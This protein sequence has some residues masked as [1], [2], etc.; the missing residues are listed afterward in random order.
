MNTGL[1]K[2]LRPVD[3]WAIA[4]GLVISGEYFGWSY[5]FGVAGTVGFLCSTLIVAVMYT[6][7]VFSLTEL[8]TA[9]PHAGGPFVYVGKAFGHRLGVLAGLA[10]MMEF[11]FA[12]PAIAFALGSY[13]HFIIPDISIKIG[14]MVVLAIF[15]I[16]NLLG[17]KQTVRFELVVT[18]IAV[19][20]LL[21]FMVLVLPHFSLDNFLAHSENFTASGIL[22]A[23]P[24]AIWFFLAIEGVAMAAEEVKDPAR[25]VPKGYLFGIATLVFLA[26]GVM[27]AAGGVGDWRI[28]STMDY[29]VPEAMAMALGRAHW[30]TRLFAGIGLFGLVASLN[31]IVYSA[32]RTV[33]ALG[34]AGILPHAFA[35]LHT[36][37]KAPQIAVIASCTVGFLGIAV[38]YTSQLITLSAMGAVL[39]YVLTMAAV[40]RLR[41]TEPLLHRPYRVPAYPLMP[42]TALVLSLV[43]LAALIY[44]NLT[45]AWWLLGLVA[46]MLFMRRPDESKTLTS[47]P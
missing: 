17:V 42:L 14:A 13:L 20:E 38:G 37:T 25:D 9:I 6:T 8:T 34:R 30:A 16:V 43:S 1:Q 15:M 18:V 45:L 10:T 4:V 41:K 24:Y 29:P 3:L 47:A 21:I 2:V 40:L 12:P 5:G 19:V 32:S 27:L 36:R 22:A 33:F 31:G 35:R 7:L 39:V 11:L 46:I 44:F 28:L 23:I 26:F